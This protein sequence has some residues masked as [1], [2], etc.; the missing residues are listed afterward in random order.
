M[1]WI[2]TSKQYQMSYKSVGIFNAV[3]PW[4]KTLII[5]MVCEERFFFYLNQTAAVSWVK[6]HNFSVQNITNTWSIYFY[7]LFLYESSQDS[8][9]SLNELLSMKVL[10]Y[11]WNTY[12]GTLWNYSW[13][14]FS[15]F[16]FPIKIFKIKS[17]FYF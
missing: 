12:K 11:L 9:F 2:P 17:N 5:D 1:L 3:P 16:F 14:N 15:E 7:Y 8:L 10:P 6:L 13:H 4:I